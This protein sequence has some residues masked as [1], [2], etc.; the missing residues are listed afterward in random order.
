MSVDATP[1]LDTARLHLRPHRLED[2]DALRA[3]FAD[4]AVL[5]PMGRARLSAEDVWNRLLRYIGHW[6]ALGYG[7][8][9]IVERDTGTFLGE[10]GFAD[11]HRGL[12]PRFDAV[13]EAGW[14]LCTQA[15]GRGIASEAVAAAHA[16]LD[17]RSSEHPRS[18]CCIGRHNLPSQRVAAGAGYHAFAETRYHDQDVVLYERPRGGR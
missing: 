7:L 4:P 12:G 9:A 18:V 15:H 3:M 1:T 2:F 17:A 11:F 8:F 10:T 13:P 14:I 16:W 6:H 5:A